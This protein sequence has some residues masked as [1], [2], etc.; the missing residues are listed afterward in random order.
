MWGEY[1]EENQVVKTAGQMVQEALQTM[2]SAEV[3]M[4]RKKTQLWALLSAL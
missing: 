3:F 2:F 1:S 4:Q